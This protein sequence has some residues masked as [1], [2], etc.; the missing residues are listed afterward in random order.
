MNEGE[1]SSIPQT[2]VFSSPNITSNNEPAQPN[3]DAEPIPQAIT[4][5][6]VAAMSGTDA[7]TV[8]AAAASLVE[9]DAPA[10]VISGAAAK[11]APT[12][13][14]Q[15][16]GARF[17]F[18]S[19]RY[20]GNNANRDYIQ[21]EYPE[22]KPRKSKKPLAIV[23]T[24]LLLAG[25][26]VGVYFLI[27]K[28]GNGTISQKT[29]DLYNTFAN[30]MLYGED[31]KDP[32]AG[33]YEYGSR[34]FYASLTKDEDREGYLKNA[35]E[36]YK[37]FKESYE[38]DRV[39]NKKLTEMI[40]KYETSL[41]LYYYTEVYPIIDDASLLVYYTDHGKEETEK[42]V[43][44]FFAAYNK[45]SFEETRSFG[46]DYKNNTIGVLVSYEVL[47]LNNCIDDEVGVVVG[48][49]RVAA[50]TPYSSDMALVENY[51]KYGREKRSELLS[52]SR[53]VFRNIW[54][55]RGNL[56]E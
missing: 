28:G 34:Y 13:N 48:R 26:G 19:R 3:L 22:E 18:G 52:L 38:Y 7:G 20:Q 44:D 32:I 12:S 11:T 24:L 45:S 36:K 23:A 2:P 41:D 43:G 5:S 14:R 40:R 55:I 51:K 49:C 50:N 37:K 46:D 16:S 10:A 1:N 47:K 27:P 6:D 29:K 31:K 42:N 30:Y 35:F 21:L 53:E 33:E 56:D 39:D 25:I 4:S 9:E 17:V 8:A 54:A 15:A